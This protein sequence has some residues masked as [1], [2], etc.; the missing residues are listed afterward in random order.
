VPRATIS[1]AALEGRHPH[2]IEPIVPPDG[3]DFLQKAR[4]MRV[5]VVA[6]ADCLAA[7][8]G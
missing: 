1:C 7:F 2:L 4:H 8:S 6:A 3:V 5:D